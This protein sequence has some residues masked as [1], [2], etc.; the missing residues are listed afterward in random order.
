MLPFL[1]DHFSNFLNKK[2]NAFEAWTRY[3]LS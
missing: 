2:I 1:K 3:I